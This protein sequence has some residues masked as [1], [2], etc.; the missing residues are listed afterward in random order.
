MFLHGK[1]SNLHC[2]LRCLLQPL[3]VNVT[4]HEAFVFFSFCSVSKYWYHRHNS[5]I[6]FHLAVDFTCYEHFLLTQPLLLIDTLNNINISMSL[7]QLTLCISWNWCKN[8]LLITVHMCGYHIPAIKVIL[9]VTWSHRSLLVLP[10][11]LLKMGSIS[12]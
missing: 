1:S 11:S 7:M 3:S 2:L 6:F 12:L 9:F 5:P 8:A 10:I 4:L